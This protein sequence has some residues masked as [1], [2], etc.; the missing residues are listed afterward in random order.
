MQAHSGTSWHNTCN[1]DFNFLLF[2]T[3]IIEAKETDGKA[4][5]TFT[6]CLY[7]VDIKLKRERHELVVMIQGVEG[8]ESRGNS[9]L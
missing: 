3:N 1:L 8:R 5:F 9:G 4:Q 6:K 2:V 7:G